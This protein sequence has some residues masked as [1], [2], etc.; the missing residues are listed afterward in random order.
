M[1][2]AASTAVKLIT[3][4]EGNRCSVLSVTIGENLIEIFLYGSVWLAANQL[5]LKWTPVVSTAAT[6]VYNGHAI[7]LYGTRED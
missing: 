6:G 3:F 2:E 1:R 7:A 5:D 4:L